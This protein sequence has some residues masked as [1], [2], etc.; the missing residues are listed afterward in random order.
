MP[1]RTALIPSRNGNSV[2]D[3]VTL[4]RSVGSRSRPMPILASL[5]SLGVCGLAQASNPQV[6]FVGSSGSTMESAVVVSNGSAAKYSAVDQTISVTLPDGSSFA[7][8]VEDVLRAHP[9]QAAALRDGLS[10]LNAD[11]SVPSSAVELSSASLVGAALPPTP[12]GYPVNLRVPT[13]SFPVGPP[14]SFQPQRAMAS[15][16]NNNFNLTGPGGGQNSPFGPCSFAPCSPWT[17]SGFRGSVRISFQQDLPSTGGAIEDAIDRYDRERWE[18]MRRDACDAAAGSGAGFTALSG[19]AFVAGCGSAA[20]V[21]GGVAL[22]GCGL[23]ATWF[24]I[25]SNR[26]AAQART[27][28]STYPG[29][30][31]W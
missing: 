31:N 2:S 29:R 23:A 16:F 3:G 30:G 6:I 25:E 14:G 1:P 26:W 9:E 11:L 4:R 27:C 24:V 20:L 12:L 5:L 28:A 22:I 7:I 13:P 19:A 10:Q 15:P 8:A 21:T 18:R 17:P